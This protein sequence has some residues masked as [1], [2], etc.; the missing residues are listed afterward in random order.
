[1]RFINGRWESV[2]ES[3]LADLNNT[4]VIVIM[5][6]IAEE[7]FTYELLEGGGS[8]LDW[9]HLVLPAFI[10]DEPEKYKQSGIYIPHGLPPGPLWPLRYTEEQAVASMSNIQYSQQPTPAK[11]EVYE[12]TW[13]K[14]HRV[15]PP[16]IKGWSITVDTATKKGKYN[17]YTVFHLWAKST[18]NKGY[19][20]CRWRG[21]VRISFLLKEF[22]TFYD[23][24][25][26]IACA[27]NY[28]GQS[29]IVKKIKTYIED[30]NSG[31]GL[32][33][34]LDLK[35]GYDVESVSRTDGKYARAVT[36][37]P[38]VMNGLISIPEG[39]DGDQHIAECVKFRADDT[40]KH[41][42]SVDCM[43]D[44]IN[45]ELPKMPA[46]ANTPIRGF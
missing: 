42:D 21:K 20:V 15:L 27:H 34:A 41:D 2:F 19:L 3:R 4:V 16:H 33:D 17:D 29:L 1:M 7:D 28:G 32:I 6:R 22:E 44:F 40:H 5:Q 43:N 14:R 23:E 35:G 13:F 30:A 39:P 24:A 11:G 31:S 38:H 10:E 9:H 36:A 18:S 37:S 8:K 26:K 46:V 12:E 25:I 45:F